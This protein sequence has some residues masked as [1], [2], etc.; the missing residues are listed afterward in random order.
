MNIKFFSTTRYLEGGY[1]TGNYANFN[2]ATHTNDDT[3]LVAKNRELLIK[4]YNLP[5][6]PKWLEQTHSTI[7]LDD[8]DKGN[9]ADSIITQTPNKVLAVLTAD[10]LP[11]FAY[12]KNKTTVGVAHSGW[13][14]LLAG[15]IEGFI[16]KFNENQIKPNDLIIH[17][18]PALS[19]ANFAVDK[20]FYQNFIDKDQDLTSCFLEFGD[21]YKFDIYAAAIITLTKLGVNKNNIYSCNDCT[22][23]NPN[24]FSYRRDGADSGRQ[25]HI[26][27]LEEND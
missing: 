12:D 1:T 13:Q 15:V 19:Q 23:T 24:L 17:F 5:Q 6:A 22:F 11:I 14:G 9:F 25:A 4:Y 20:D 16:A 8:N 21:K 18:S 27:Y 3:L 26:I 10:C 7:C 2:L